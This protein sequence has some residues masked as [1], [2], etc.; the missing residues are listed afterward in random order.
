MLRFHSLSCCSIGSPTLN[1]GAT[2]Q[3]SLRFGYGCFESICGKAGVAR[4]SEAT[5]GNALKP[6]CRYAHA[7]YITDFAMTRIT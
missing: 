6:A 7:G 1:V 3:R 2:R 5:S 4:M